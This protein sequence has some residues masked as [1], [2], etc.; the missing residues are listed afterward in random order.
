MDHST[1]YRGEMCGVFHARMS[2]CHGRP[3]IFP[4]TGDRKKSKTTLPVPP[5]CIPGLPFFESNYLIDNLPSEGIDS[6]QVLPS[7]NFKQLKTAQRM[8]RP[9]RMG[10]KSYARFLYFW[11]ISRLSGSL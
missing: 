2:T 7:F 6:H 3:L 5:F 10:L 8:C 1:T 9:M 4:E 11:P